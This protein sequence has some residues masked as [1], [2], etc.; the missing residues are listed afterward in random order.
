MTPII[1][2]GEAVRAILDGRKTM[3]RRVLKPQPHAGIRASVFVPSGVEDGHGREVKVRYEVGTKLWVRETWVEKAWTDAECAR[4]GCLSAPTDPTM[5]YLGIRMRAIHKASC[6]VDGAGPW[7]SP[8]F[9]PRWASRLTLEVTELRIER[10]QAISEADAVA[11]GCTGSEVTTPRKEFIDRWD[12]INGHRYP[13]A[14]NCWVYAVGFR[15]V[16]R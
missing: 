8:I 16:E 14:D 6:V 15:R 9:M 2:D 5:V 12:A 3:T 1:F 7:R 11:E 4:S 10:L 13:W